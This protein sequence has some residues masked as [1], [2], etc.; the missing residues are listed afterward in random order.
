MGKWEMV[1]LGDIVDIINGRSH[2][3]VAN[4]K[5]I[6]PIY[7]SGGVMGYADDYICEKDTVV[8]GRK[9]TINSPIYV[10]EP[11]WNVDT[12][13]GLRPNENK[14]FPKYLYY[15]CEEFDFE[16]INTTVTIPSLTKSNLSKVQIPL[17]PLSIQ[18]KIAD[19]LDHASALIQKRKAQIE[20]L[21]LLMRMQFITMFGDMV[22]NALG[23][24]VK[25]LDQ[26]A[27]SRLGKMLDTKRQT[28]K[29]SY[30]YLA[31]FNVQWFRLNL[32]KLNEMDFDEVDR[33]EF[34][35]KYG[36]LL[37]C[38]G[39][40]VGRSA[41]WKNEKQDCFFQKAIHRVR[42]KAGICVPEYLAWVMFQKATT[43]NFDGLVTSA[44]I[45]HLTG[46]KLKGLMIQVPPLDRQNIFAEFVRQVDKSKLELQ[47]GL[48]KL[49]LLYKSLMQ[50]YFHG[51][52]F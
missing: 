19:V 12:A 32:E 51:E 47:H 5:G 43:T 36:D 20:K 2:R 49:E 45:A 40:E 50:K 35:L 29:N 41:I 9:G 42:C 4:P 31:N 27:D 39:G 48:N 8:I 25:R 11:F 18:Q 52:M 7:G 26:I 3:A 38:E 22:V 23:W 6:Y 30:P 34:S 24:D 14:I 10:G 44:T 28:G 37:V 21:Y 46:E 17:P 33:V 1:Q 13:F 16:N 15:F